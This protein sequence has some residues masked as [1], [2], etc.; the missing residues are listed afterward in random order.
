MAF[1]KTKELKVTHKNDFVPLLAP[2]EDTKG[3]ID[4]KKV[5][6]VTGVLP[7]SGVMQH[8]DGTLIPTIFMYIEGRNSE[9][10]ATTRTLAFSPLSLAHVANLL[11][12]MSLMLISDPESLV[13][14]IASSAGLVTEP[15]KVQVTKK[16]EGYL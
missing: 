16:F 9:G 3:R 5:E 8:D 1:R 2:N 12:A 15:E 6:V 10:D 14:E 13:K 11:G 7:V 4:L